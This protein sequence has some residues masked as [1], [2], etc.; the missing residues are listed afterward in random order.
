MLHRFVRVMVMA[1]LFLSA[2]YAIYSPLR[3][4][5]NRDLGVVSIGQ[6]SVAL[7]ATGGT[8][9][10]YTWT[11]ASGTL[12]PGINIST[13]PGNSSQ[14]GLVGVA[15]CGTGCTAAGGIFNFSLTVTD[16]D[17]HTVTEPFE[18]R[19]STLTLQDINLPD[20]FAGVKFSYQFTALNAQGGK[21][22]FDAANALPLGLTLS[23]TGL[24]SGTVP[25]PG[26]YSI[27][28]SIND[29]TDEIYRNFTLNVYQFSVAV[30]SGAAF[31]TQTTT[32]CSAGV[33]PNAVQGE[34]YTATL[35]ATG[36]T[37][38]YQ[39][40]FNN[41]NLPNGLS[42]NNDGSVTGSANSGPG[43]Y[44]FNVSVE[45]AAGNTY[46][47]Q[48]S[49][50]VLPGGITQNQVTVG[51][52]YDAIVGAG[53]GSQIPTCCGGIP[54]FTWSATGL[55]PGLSLRTGSGVTSDYI[56]PGWAEIWG[57][58]TLAGNY[59]VTVTVTDANKDQ[60]SLTFPFHVSQMMLAPSPNLPNGTLGTPYSSTF[61]IIGG[62]PPYSSVQV[63]N[64]ALPDGL[65]FNTTNLATGFFTVSGTPLENGQ[66]FPDIQV[67]DSAGMPNTLTVDEN[68]GINNG[69][70]SINANPPFFI[71]QGTNLAGNQLNACCVAS[72]IWSV[73]SGTPPPEFS[74]AANGQLSGTLNT[75]GTY[76]FLVEAAD[77][78][79][80]ANPGFKQ[81]TIIVTPITITTN[82]LPSGNV[83][84]AYSQT[85]TSTGGTGTLTWSLLPG[86]YLPPGITLNPS[87]G[88]LTG[89]P[90]LT[91]QFYF[92]VKVV[93]QD[94]NS[95]QPSYGINIYGK[96]QLA[97]LSVSSGPNLGT[98]NTGTDWIGL[99][100]NGG[101]GTYTYSLTSGTLPPGLFLS[102]QVPGSFAKNQQAGVIGVATVPGT[103]NFSIKITSTGA[104]APYGGTSITVPYQLTISS[105]NLQD[106]TPP[107]GFMG[108]AYN[109]Q[110]TPI[111]NQ[112]SVTFSPNCNNRTF[113]MPPGLSLSAS[114]QLS[115]TPTQ[116]GSF[117]LAMNI[118]DGVSSVY[119][120]Y[121]LHIYAVQITTSPVLPNATQNAVYSGATLAATGG[122][123]TSYTFTI[124][125]GG[126]PAGMG[127]DS[128]GNI[129]GTP[130]SGPGLYSLNV[131]ATDTGNTA[132]A[133][134]LQMSLDVV[135]ASNPASN[136]RITT[137][138][139]QDPVFGNHYG[140]VGS[141][142]CG[143]TG[144]FTWTITGLPT[145][146]TY[147][148][149]SNSDTNYAATPGDVQIYGIAEE[150]GTFPVT[151][152]VTDSTNASTSVEFPMHVSVLDE[153]DASTGNEFGLPG[154]TLGSAYSTSF[155]VIG[156]SGTGYAVATTPNGEMPS[157]LKFSGL[158]LSGTPAESGGVNQELVF[159]DS[160]KNT[161]TR[162]QG[163]FIADPNEVN[164]YLNGNGW[165]GFDLLS[166]P[167]NTSYSTQFNA[168]CDGPYTWSL[169][170]GSTL[171]AGL[172][173]NPSTGQ[174]SGTTAKAT[175]TTTS[176]FLIQAT[177]SSNSAQFG[178]KSYTLTV[179]PI[180]IS[181]SG[182]PNGTIETPYSQ[183]L[184]ATGSKGTLTWSLPFNEGSAL[185]P[186][187]TLNTSTGVI[188]GT[189]TSAGQ[190]FF[191]VQV[192][193][194]SKN[195]AF[196]GYG[197]NIASK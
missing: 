111:K 122:T 34:N 99:G 151:L 85:L 101:S 118:N 43:L 92:T 145:G 126:L 63:T 143:G 9:T 134:F 80:E 81:F 70:I 156:G 53:Y 91:G 84:T 160:A 100:I 162:S 66:F 106:A 175:T 115:G 139:L 192:S 193:D 83:G 59:N 176:T 14:P 109:Y 148:P 97:P 185:P 146:L 61:Q 11:L 8:N 98:W 26:S 110:F 168:C 64:G 144:P 129:T 67:K 119:T 182:L 72:Y 120:Q 184:T 169:P 86:N 21:A 19:I 52:I 82:N 13:I 77:A 28:I 152:T 45:D 124:I 128:S 112:G 117:N 24:L 155:H 6:V 22:S 123:N 136:M 89:S 5:T 195:T 3:I 15:V 71:T 186:G 73:A 38:P 30:G 189:P 79:S 140:A 196:Q 76:T 181:P 32:V 39:F 108:V 17:S 131:L 96:G 190:Y 105:L 103:Y 36:G 10:G 137:T 188:S 78:A 69:G 87:T 163:I 56:S 37:S 153:V 75:P 165:F 7:T 74:L 113:C 42:L 55:P 107:D 157:G 35:T 27:K 65:T 88:Q 167:A 191:T 166:V 141:V 94:G 173:L 154:G 179:T 16:S 161:L 29:G 50:T 135:P 147:E 180:A 54:P 4:T 159:S 18:I 41:G 177:N 58:P 197:L 171:P 49:I 194:T 142:C 1:S 170:K 158:T 125:G 95:R 114:G 132:N 116:A 104:G 48:L 46:T 102:S 62:T 44:G 90:T 93:D 2:S 187:L 47:K 20:A 121:N 130:T 12:P 138:W 133:G 172:T 183:T 174:I 150:T 23:S 25:Y 40:F 164:L 51:T 60:S 149:N 33:L 57:V 127:M 31:C 68:F 178:V